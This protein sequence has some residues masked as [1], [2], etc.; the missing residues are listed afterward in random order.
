VTRPESF[1]VE[2]RSSAPPEVVFALLADAA[3]WSGWAGPLVLGSSWETDGPQ[4]GVGA[5]LR[6]GLGPLATRLRV[7]EHDAPRR[8]AFEMLTWQPYRDYL[9][10]VQLDQDGGGTWTRWTGGFRPRVPGTGRAQRLVLQS[11]VGDF[12]TRLAAHA[13]KSVEKGAIGK[14]APEHRTPS[15]GE[16]T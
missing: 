3:S 16:P 1:T 5:V 7:V 13:G 8:L 6:L 4:G 14:T 2:T 12:A 9:C 15:T 10:E 11:I